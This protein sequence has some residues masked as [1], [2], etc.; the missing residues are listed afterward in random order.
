MFVGAVSGYKLNFAWLAK[1]AAA[2]PSFSIAVIGP[3]GVGDADS[4]ASSLR[5]DNIHLLGHR[6]YDQLP[7]YLKGADVAVIPY[8]D[9]RYT[10]HC[11]PIKFFEML[12]TGLPV[13]ISPLPALSDYFDHVLVAD[14]AD[15]FV[16]RCDEAVAH[17]ERGRETRLALARDNSWSSRVS[18]LMQL[19]E[20]QL[21]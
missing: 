2:R 12:A 10:A 19:V 5:R 6:S 14:S 4:D 3:E 21:P 11:F 7:A 1:L 16:A 20:Q 17:P 8:N 9:N 18:R 15:A 13:V